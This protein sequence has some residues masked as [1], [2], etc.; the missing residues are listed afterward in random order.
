[1]HNHSAAFAAAEGEPPQNLAIIV[2]QH[3]TEIENLKKTDDRIEKSLGEVGA[4]ID[5]LLYFVLGTLGTAIVGLFV[6]LF[7][8]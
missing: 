3:G 8:H 6:S 2:G 7:H 1:M 5:K 4:K